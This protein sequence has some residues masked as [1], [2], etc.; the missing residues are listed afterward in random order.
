[1][2]VLFCTKCHN[3]LIFWA[4][5]SRFWIEVGMESLNKFWQN[6]EKQNGRQITKLSKTHSFLELQSP[7][8]AWKLILTGASAITLCVIFFQK[9]VPP[10]LCVFLNFVRHDSK[11]PKIDKFHLHP[12][13]FLGLP[14]PPTPKNSKFVSRAQAPKKFRKWS[15]FRTTSPPYGFWRE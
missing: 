3:L 12:L 5:D 6:F 4:T 15:L 9:V 10:I 1:M 11:P 13:P 7:D 2:S 8:F 14:S